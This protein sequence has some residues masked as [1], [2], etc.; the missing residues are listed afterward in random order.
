MVPPL[1]ALPDSGCSACCDKPSCPRRPRCAASISHL[2]LEGKT[3]AP[4]RRNGCANWPFWGREAERSSCA[5]LVTGGCCGLFPGDMQMIGFRF[6]DSWEGSRAVSQPGPPPGSHPVP[7]ASMAH[8]G[9]PLS[10]VGNEWTEAEGRHL[11]A[12]VYGHGR[13]GTPICTPGPG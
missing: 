9:A 13:A 11:R 4:L 10:E 2:K 12:A 3:R 7:R 5:D 1:A 8:C 6:H